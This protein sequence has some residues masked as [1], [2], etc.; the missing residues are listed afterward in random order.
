MT[1]LEDNLRNKDNPRNEKDHKN[2][3]NLM[4]E[5]H[6]KIEIQ[7]GTELCQTQIKLISGRLFSLLVLVNLEQYLLIKLLEWFI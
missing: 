4:Y 7:A 1:I 3:D 2:E 5:G 6:L